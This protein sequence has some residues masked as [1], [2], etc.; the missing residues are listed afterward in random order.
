MEIYL[1]RHTTPNVAK[2][3]CY[4]QS[5]LELENTFEQELVIVKENLPNFTNTPVYSSPLKRCKLLAQ[6]LSDGVVYDDRLK[7]INFG[8]WEMKAWNNIPAEELNPWMENYFIAAPPEGES[9]QE[10]EARVLAFID[11]LKQQ[12]LTKAIV[13]THG[14]VI[15][16]LKG[17]YEKLPKDEWM[18][19]PLEY[20]AVV[21]L[22]I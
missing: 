3:I 1:V 17:Y 4:G 11:D 2:G 6:A 8:T 9:M 15:K 21:R 18:M 13:V 7:E 12:Q 10:L 5:D 16:V 20:G 14:G 19:Q 22:N